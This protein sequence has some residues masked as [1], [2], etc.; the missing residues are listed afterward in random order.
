MT[1]RNN[2]TRDTR[3]MHKAIDVAYNEQSG[4][5]KM[6]GGILGLLKRLFV[7]DAIKDLGAPVTP[8]SIIAF[9]NSSTSTAWV[10]VSETAVDPAAPSAS[11][12]NSIALRPSDYT[13][14]ALPQKATKLRS[15][16]TSVVAYLMV[17]DSAIR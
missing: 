8:G 7:L 5:I 15:S 9:Y 4:G 10:T 2:E 3:G 16:D 14:L 1:S 6:T 17:D 12:P 11:E 13:L